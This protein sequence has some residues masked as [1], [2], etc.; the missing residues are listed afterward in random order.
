MICNYSILE[1]I[2]SLLC[3]IF[4]LFCVPQFVTENIGIE[5]LIMK[6]QGDLTV[7]DVIGIYVI[8]KIVSYYLKKTL[9]IC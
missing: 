3:A 4:D 2:N 1:L 5:G 9:V 8:K 6:P 7:F